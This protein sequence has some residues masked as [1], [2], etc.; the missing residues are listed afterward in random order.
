[1]ICFSLVVLACA[2]C[3]G[4][5]AKKAPST[6]LVVCSGSECDSYTGTPQEQ[7]YSSLETAVTKA[8]EDGSKYTEIWVTPGTYSV[9]S[10]TL[11]SKDKTSLTIRG[12]GAGTASG[13]APLMPEDVIISRG[14]AMGPVL[15]SKLKTSSTVTL[16]GLTF[17]GGNGGVLIS[18]GA[19]TIAQCSIRDCGGRGVVC[20]GEGKATIIN[21]S[22]VKNA[23]D[24]VYVASAQGTDITLSSIL[25]NGGSGVYKANTGKVSV[26]ACN[27]AYNGIGG[28]GQDAKD[29]FTEDF[30]VG[31]NAFDLT[32][33]SMTF[34][35]DAS[36]DYYTAC[37]GAVSAFP[38]TP[39]AQIPAAI[40]SSSDNGSAP[41]PMTPGRYA[42]LYGARY[43][44][45]FVNTNGSVTFGTGDNSSVFTL[46]QHFSAPRVSGMLAD[47][48]IG[49]R[50]DYFSEEFNGKPSTTNDLNGTSLTFTPRPTRSATSQLIS[51]S[52]DNFKVKLETGVLPSNS[53][54]TV[55]PF[56]QPGGVLN[57]SVW[58]DDD[59]RRV[60]LPG[61]VTIPDL[62]T[63]QPVSSFYVCSNGFVYFDSAV[64]P[65]PYAINNADYRLK[66]HFGAKRI[67]AQFDDLNPE[68]GGEIWC[69]QIGTA[70][71]V[72]GRIVV[73]WTGLPQNAALGAAIV[74]VSLE[75]YFDGRIR[76]THGASGSNR[77]IVG[78]SLGGGA[79]LDFD[80]YE[81]N[82]SD[83]ATSP[84]VA[85]TA[86]IYYDEF[87]DSVA[88][89]FDKLPAKG[90]G[91]LNRNSFQIEFFDD[92]SI[93]MT[94]LEV[95]TKTGVVGLSQGSQPSPYTASNFRNSYGVCLSE[96]ASVGG[97][98]SGDTNASGLSGINNNLFGNSQPFAPAT[99][100]SKLSATKY[101]FPSLDY[102][103]TW[104][105]KLQP[106][107]NDLIDRGGSVSGTNGGL[108]FEGDGRDEGLCDIGADEVNEDHSG[109]GAARW[110]YCAI[111]TEDPLAQ[112]VAFRAKP[113]G[114]LVIYLEV[115]GLAVGE[116][117]TGRLRLEGPEVDIR[118]EVTQVVPG[119][120]VATN[121]DP[122]AK[123]GTS[124]PDGAATVYLDV[125]GTA[126]Q[127]APGVDDARRCIVDTTPPIMLV[128][129][130]SIASTFFVSSN[131]TVIAD[132]CIG[133]AAH[134]YYPGDVLYGNQNVLFSD[135]PVEPNPNGLGAKA[136]FNTGS[137]TNNVAQVPLEFKLQAFFVDKP[138]PGRAGAKV[139]GFTYVEE[140]YALTNSGT[141]GL[142][143]NWVT[144]QTTVESCLTAEIPFLIDRYGYPFPVWAPVSGSTTLNKLTVAGIDSYFVK[145]S[146][147]QNKNDSMEIRWS[148]SPSSVSG[149]KL[150]PDLA[151]AGTF[152]VATRF[153]ARDRAGNLMESSLDPVEFWWL[154]RTETQLTPNVDRGEV[155][156]PDFGWEIK[157]GADLGQ[158]ARVYPQFAYRLM[159]KAEGE[160]FDAADG[161]WRWDGAYEPVTGLF[162]L[163]GQ[164][165][166]TWFPWPATRGVNLRDIVFSYPDTCMLLVAV[167]VD[168]AG[169][170]EPWPALAL[171]MDASG[172]VHI[173]GN[174]AS[175]PN[176][177]R[178]V[179]PTP[180]T[181]VDTE[182]AAEFWHNK[183][184]LPE[185]GSN[186]DDAI[187]E[188]ETY[189]GPQT[190]LPRPSEQTQR[191]EGKFRIAGKVDDNV[192]GL[193][194]ARIELEKDGV[195]VMSGLAFLDESA[196]F[197]LVL[198]LFCDGFDGYSDIRKNL[199]D[200][201]CG[202]TEL[203]ER[204]RTVQYLL[205]AWAFVDNVNVNNALDPGEPVDRSPATFAFTVTDGPIKD[206]VEQRAPDEQPVKAY[207]HVFENE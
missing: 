174:I 66:A 36:G 60:D 46:A 104:L 39:G 11:M 109:G 4:A 132:S 167:S 160:S 143:F 105:G 15:E 144:P 177:C 97:I 136:F 93:R 125:N 99:I 134:P 200:P 151:K 40:F 178:F 91:G 62:A 181:R 189:F 28:T 75:M 115:T 88:V 128:T 84:A 191:L 25:Y 38:R 69:R 186:F 161:N 207:E 163:N 199:I 122:I 147:A 14:N 52:P 3:S 101:Y 133:D 63:G 111:D 56:V 131:D 33:F 130:Q 187:G 35:P 17:T 188:D 55:I 65:N 96:S 98:A 170:V 21:C 149:S 45:L 205:R 22:I 172:T 61:G 153:N 182:V 159:K 9:S 168:E 107:P 171:P 145:G 126:P 6:V 68:A 166:S 47:L 117:P 150:T 197:N 19:V 2:F 114:G 194:K 80:T 124:Y 190:M 203:G 140:A 139:S 113:V 138:P 135:S 110:V 26:S 54:G 74:N 7:I 13:E 42:Y 79:P 85:D 44:K 51:G 57:D 64:M 18:Q 90:E 76:I 146:S 141:T 201:V 48:G 204:T 183:M 112:P 202:L 59:F 72:D 176:W 20:D 82:L 179:C 196:S 29:P 137:Y 152:H 67:S 119:R 162:G 34:R 1:V 70:T 73:G 180:E 192:S 123:V 106:A 32:N 43:D 49:S 154:V 86:K 23:T 108:D 89:T 87:A 41:A 53:V 198:P 120:F 94:W 173:T 16:V 148:V 10:L 118:L 129:A 103:A 206:F 102:S 158:T 157:R 77:G 195:V 95:T 165:W 27:I 155:S 164:G 121:M 30:A 50:M 175:G 81:S 12:T 184:S 83:Y 156:F 78:I 24:G 8:L 193:R 92:E 31:G 169:N 37:G 142:A 185:N 100:T 116:V 127:I 71:S 58:H 5:W